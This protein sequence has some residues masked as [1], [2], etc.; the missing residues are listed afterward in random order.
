MNIVYANHPFQNL[1][2]PEPGDQSL[3]TDPD[4]YYVLFDSEKNL[5]QRVQ[6]TLR[7]DKHTHVLIPIEN[8]GPLFDDETFKRLYPK[9]PEV[10]P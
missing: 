2:T 9:Q 8:T 3:H 7:S 5:A 4:A 10:K 1:S 6:L